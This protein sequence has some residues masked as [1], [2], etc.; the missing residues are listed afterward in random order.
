MGIRLSHIFP[1]SAGTY[2]EVTEIGVDVDLSTGLGPYE[3]CIEITNYHDYEVEQLEYLCPGIG[4]V[5]SIYIGEGPPETGMELSEFGN[6]E[7]E[8]GP[9]VQEEKAMPWIPLLLLDN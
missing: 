1:E 3:N 6:D 7:P 2:G 4:L 9:P 5:K 8:P